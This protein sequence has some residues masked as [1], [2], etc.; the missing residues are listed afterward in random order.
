MPGTVSPPPLLYADTD[1]SADMLYF[2]GVSVPDSF[3]AFAAKGK[4]Y[5]VVSALEFGRVRKASDFDVV[6]PLERCLQQAGKLWPHLKP[7]PAGVIRLLAR[8]HRIA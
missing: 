5:A 1:R 2:G 4:K 3:V 8:E 7:G 6:L